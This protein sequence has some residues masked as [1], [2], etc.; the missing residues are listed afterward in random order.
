MMT[1]FLHV[2]MGVS[3]VF[4]SALALTRLP[5]PANPP[6]NQ[7]QLLA[8]VIQP[9]V[10]FTV[11]GSIIVRTYYFCLSCDNQSVIPHPD[12]LSI[13]FFNLGR[14]VHSRTV[15][16]TSTWTRTRTGATLPDWVFYARRP[17][18]NTGALTA[19]DTDV[20]VECG[21]E[22]IGK[23]ESVTEA[24]PS[25]TCSGPSSPAEIVTPTAP[26]EERVVTI[27]HRNPGSGASDVTNEP[28]QVCFTIMLFPLMVR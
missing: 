25:Q 17:E 12:G 28:T 1:V 13:P 9:I 19:T 5:V 22:T 26:V 21:V 6:A 23:G 20:D 10:S 14:G 27:S 7:A 16:L 18:N 3:A 2:Q 4:V 15:T 11:L 24:G 8:V